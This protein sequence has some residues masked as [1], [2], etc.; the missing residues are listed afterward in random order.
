MHIER[1][2]MGDDEYH[3]ITHTGSNLSHVGGIGYTVIDSLDTM[4][5]MG[6]D[7]EVDRA[8]A[9]IRDKLSFDRDDSFNLFEVFLNSYFGSHIFLKLALDYYPRVG[10]F[11]FGISPLGRGS[12]IPRKS[13]RLGRSLATCLQ[14]TFRSTTCY[15][16]SCPK[17]SS[18]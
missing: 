17:R 7:E 16:K 4:I 6:L 3:P 11:T 2:A 8:K 18:S 10:W 1:D 15:V 14:N 13:Y 12:F 9:W 5:I